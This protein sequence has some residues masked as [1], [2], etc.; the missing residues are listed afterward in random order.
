MAKRKHAASA[1]DNT[2]RMEEVADFVR[3]YFGWDGW[4]SLLGTAA[5]TADSAMPQAPLM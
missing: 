3:P 2:R 4:K 5:A 1:K